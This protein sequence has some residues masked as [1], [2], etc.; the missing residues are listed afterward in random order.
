MK[1]Q[2]WEQLAVKSSYSPRKLAELCNVSLRTLQ[3]HFATHYHTSL[4]EWLRSF[5]LNAARARVVSGEP[6]KS[7]AYDLCYKQLSHFSKAFK[8]LHGVPPSALSCHTKGRLAEIH[9][10]SDARRDCRALCC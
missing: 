4:G 9:S 5:R 8:N 7:V 1:E 10:P 3:R 2:T 6:I